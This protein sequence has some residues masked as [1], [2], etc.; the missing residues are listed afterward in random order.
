[1]IAKFCISGLVAL[2]PAAAFAQ[3]LPQTHEPVS[4]PGKAI[5]AYR[6]IERTEAAPATCH[7]DGTKAVA[8]EARAQ[9]ARVEALARK[10]D[11]EA[12]RLGS[13]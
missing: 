3:D 7:P 5:A 6:P 2:L 4:V 11:E 9:Q 13:R 10:R 1:M 12:V 8:C